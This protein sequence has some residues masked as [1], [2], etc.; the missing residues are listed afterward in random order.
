MVLKRNVNNMLNTGFWRLTLLS[1]LFLQKYL[2]RWCK[3]EILFNSATDFLNGDIWKEN[4]AI[5]HAAIPIFS[6]VAQT[7]QMSEDEPNPYLRPS[8]T[9]LTEPFCKNSEQVTALNN[10]SEK[11]P[12]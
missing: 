3:H 1:L 2:K 4:D 12:S 6:I 7:F 5:V 8:R 10:F 11:A 9:S